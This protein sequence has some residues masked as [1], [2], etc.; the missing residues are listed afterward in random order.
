MKIGERILL[1]IFT[2]IVIFLSVIAI[3]LP[4]NI[5]DVDTIQA[6]VYNYMNT[7]IYAIIPLLL[8]IMGFS[9]MFIGVK[10][11]KARLGI[12]HTNEFGNLLISP[13]TFESAGYN[14]VKDIK[15]IKDAS[16]EIEFDESGVIYYID[17]IVTNDVN[18]PE[19]TKEVQNAIKSHVE[20]AIGIPVKAINFHVKDMVAPQV[21]ITHLR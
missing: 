15:G 19:L 20:V 13:K 1:T 21:P 4:L 7:P 12:I 3:L 18:V 10:K 8:I 11:K 14:A 5:F 2:L 16:I 6:A 17:A 9:V